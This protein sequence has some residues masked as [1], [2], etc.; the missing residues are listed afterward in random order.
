MEDALRSV[1]ST[2]RIAPSVSVNQ[3]FCFW[4]TSA[5][6]EVREEPHVHLIWL[7]IYLQYDHG[8][9]FFRQPDSSD[10]R[11]ST[12]GMLFTF[13]FFLSWGGLD[14]RLKACLCI[15]DLCLLDLWFWLQT[16]CGVLI[17]PQMPTRLN[18]T[19]WCHPRVLNSWP[20]S[21]WL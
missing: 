16:S 12:F 19:P 8:I 11:S 2:N 20:I 15:L 13:F 5:P 17:Q 14:T 1:M 21:V 3:G 4:R 18:I 6:V 9:A 10:Y 7:S